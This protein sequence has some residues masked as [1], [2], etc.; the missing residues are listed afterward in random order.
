MPGCFPYNVAKA[1]LV[2]MVQSLAIELGP[3]I[4]TV[5]VAPGFIDTPSNDLWFKTFPDAAAERARTESRHPVR[6]IGTPDE[7]G[8]LCAFLASGLTGFI[9]GTTLLVDGGMDALMS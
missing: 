1:G 8:S 6:R 4:R 9:T 2:A 7:I 3:Q 5:G